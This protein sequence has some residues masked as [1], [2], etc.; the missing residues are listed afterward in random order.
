MNLNNS[1]NVL[2]LFGTKG[3]PRDPYGYIKT[4]KFKIENIHHEKRFLYILGN[5]GLQCGSRFKSSF[6][7]LT[8]ISFL[9]D[10]YQINFLDFFGTKINSSHNAIVV[11]LLRNTSKLRANFPMA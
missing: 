2:W 5:P 9:P 3:T 4:K 11:K 10:V 8:K 7:V 1:T 6:Y